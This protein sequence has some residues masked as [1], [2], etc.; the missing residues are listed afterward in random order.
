MS[1]GGSLFGNLEGT[2]TD[3][4]G[5]LRVTVDVDQA[6]RAREATSIQ[7]RKNKKEERL[8]RRRKLGGVPGSAAAG[9]GASPTQAISTDRLPE[10]VNGIMSNDTELQKRYA[11]LFRRLL[12]I[13]RNP[14]ID[15]VIKAGVVPKFVE[16]LQRNDSPTLQFEAAWALTNIASGTSN[17][18][19]VVINSGAV[20]I[21]VNLLSSASDEVR[22]QAVWALGNVA[23]DSANCRDLVLQ[24]GA[25]PALLAQL[26][27]NSKV[28][29]LRNAT[30]TISNFCRGKPPPTFESVAKALPSLATLVFM[31]DKEVLTDA[32]WALSYLSDG[33]NDKIQAVIN[34]NVVPRCVELLQHSDVSV[35]TPALRTVGNIVT[36]DDKQTQV[37][38]QTNALQYLKVL[39]GSH[40]KGIRKEA[41]WTLSNITAGNANQIQAVINTDIFPTLISMLSTEQFE[42]QKEAAWAVSNATAGGNKEQVLY[43]VEKGCVKPLCDLLDVPDSRIV[44]VALEGIENVLKTGAKETEMSGGENVISRYVEEAGGLLK[45]EQLQTHK[46]KTVWQKS[47]RILCNFFDAETEEAE[48]APEENPSA[49]QFNFGMN[50][51]NQGQGFSSFN[52]GGFN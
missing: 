18:T 36:G 9:S 11:M 7:L 8:N 16:F 52:G 17:H 26:Q 39:L 49:Q 35:Q 14:P 21:F 23:G 42:I 43:L 3:S 48:L 38:L 24:H 5:Q 28:S 40:K 10:M 33:T 4:R 19:A 13:E 37:V 45:I 31:S 1:A 30:W 27:Q 47:S 20:P 32:C 6:R 22:E 34:A 29:M 44:M 15:L 2:S 51:N 12:S 50:Q 25:L 41:C 46:D